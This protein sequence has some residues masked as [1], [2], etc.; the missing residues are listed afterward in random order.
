M[1]T[2]PGKEKQQ[3][4]IRQHDETPW[5]TPGT[6]AYVQAHDRPCSVHVMLLLEAGCPSNSDSAVLPLKVFT[7]CKS[8]PVMPD[9][10]T[11]G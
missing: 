3:S 8:L 6:Q 5:K 1:Q 2:L 11:H 7:D 9:T 10:L 4:N